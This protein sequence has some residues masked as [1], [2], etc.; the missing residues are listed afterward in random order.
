MFLLNK[1]FFQLF[2]VMSTFREANFLTVSN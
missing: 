2:P 1:A